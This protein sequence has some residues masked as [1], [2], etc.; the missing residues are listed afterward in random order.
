MTTM[1]L[2]TLRRQRD[3]SMVY[4]PSLISRLRI[5]LPRISLAPA[6]RLFLVALAF[7][8]RHALVV[9]GCAALVIGAATLSVTAAWIMTAASLFFL[10]ARRR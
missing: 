3:E 8:L 9:A 1:T 4:R 7:V 6:G 10:E 2:A 5:A